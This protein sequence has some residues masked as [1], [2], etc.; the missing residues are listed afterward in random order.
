MENLENAKK[1][2]ERERGKL[3]ISFIIMLDLIRFI[4]LFPI[5]NYSFGLT[6]YYNFDALF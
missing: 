4:F 6:N 3:V 2:I 1:Q 5:I